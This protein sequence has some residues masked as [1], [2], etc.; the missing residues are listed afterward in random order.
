M[1]LV[2]ILTSQ[3]SGPSSG[4]GALEILLL[5]LL[6]PYLLLVYWIFPEL[7]LPARPRSLARRVGYFLFAGLTVGLGPWLWYF[8]SVDA[9]LRKMSVRRGEDESTTAGQAGCKE[10][11]NGVSVDNRASSARRQ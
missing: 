11:R 1:W 8:W 9:V 4:P 2:A 6:L 7:L 3:P 5:A 10:R